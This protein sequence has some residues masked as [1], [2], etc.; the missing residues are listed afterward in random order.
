MMLYVLEKCTASRGFPDHPEEN[1]S[2]L[3]KHVFPR[4]VISYTT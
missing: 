2:L 3:V 1:P 4:F